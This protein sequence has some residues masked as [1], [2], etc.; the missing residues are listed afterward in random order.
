MYSV[1]DHKNAVREAKEDISAVY[2]R[3]DGEYPFNFTSKIHVSYVKVSVSIHVG[4]KHH[5]RRLNV[6][7]YVYTD[8]HS[9]E[10][11][12]S[13]R[14]FQ[15]LCDVLETN[16]EAQISAWKRV[17]LPTHQTFTIAARFRFYIS[18]TTD[19]LCYSSSMR[20]SFSFC[21]IRQRN[22]GKASIVNIFQYCVG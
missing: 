13:I 18:L 12:S 11:A 21:C 4:Q 9:D 20:V 3:A 6:L 14:Q 22:R 7:H 1:S 19:W 16:T 8:M 2:A 17:Y 10:T 15:G 5:P